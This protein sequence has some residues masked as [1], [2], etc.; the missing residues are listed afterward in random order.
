MA[1]L[2]ATW[3]LL[4][5][6]ALCQVDALPY[7]AVDSC[8]GRCDAPLDNA[9][10]CQ[11]NSACE[12]YGDCCADYSSLCNSLLSC[13][14][15]CN[16]AYVATNPCHCNSKCPQ[17]SN[18]CSDYNALCEGGAPPSPTLI[19]EAEVQALTEKLLS[20]DTNRAAASD[21]SLN[22]QTLIANSQ[23]GAGTDHSSQRL[24][25]SVNEAALFNRPT[26]ASF[27]A[28]RD[29]YAR[30]TGTTE[31]FTAAQ[32]EEQLNFLSLALDTPL[33]KELF[34][35]LQSKERYTTVEEFKLDLQKMWFGLYSRY[36]GAQDSSG[37]EHIFLGEIKGGK[38]SGFH[39]WVSFYFLEKEGKLNYFSHNWDGPWTSYPDVLAMQFN[40]DGYFKEVGSAF[41]GSSPEFDLAIYSLCFISK[42]DGACKIKLDGNIIG[43]Q[44]YT[45]TNSSYDNGKKYV[46][47]A[48]PISP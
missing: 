45:W 40:W 42:P 39:N 12:R 27:I 26:F 28:L 17:Y 29:N 15:R 5:L 23:T 19:T 36:N 3:T 35:F 32:L 30:I 44:T 11:C 46:A 13:K 8:E 38:V 7:R 33:M 18:C 25:T 14:G 34:L 9:F 10:T 6:A 47:S 20:L 48:Y 37:F 2:I 4:A 1:L 16:E 41:I 31:A 24:F 22:K 43:I 21:I